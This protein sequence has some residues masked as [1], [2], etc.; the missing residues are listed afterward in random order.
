MVHS[1]SGVD[2]TP[3]SEEVE[4]PEKTIR[5]NEIRNEMAR[6]LGDLEEMTPELVPNMTMRAEIERLTSRRVEELRQELND[7]I[8]REEPEAVVAPEASDDREE[9][10]ENE[11]SQDSNG[12]RASA[13]LWEEVYDTKRRG[14]EMWLT[15]YV[16]GRPA[17]SCWTL[18]RTG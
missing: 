12:S 5:Q 13:L 7:I 6:L 17:A 10:E 4:L 15:T 9:S 3:E 18:T 2:E 16:G 1:G 8:A 11:V 14:T